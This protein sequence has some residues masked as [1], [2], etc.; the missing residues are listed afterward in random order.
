MSALLEVEG[1]VVRYGPAIAVD[2]VSLKL[3]AGERVA[4]I[5]PNGAGKSSLLNAICGL[6]KPAAGRVRVGG[7]NVTGR[8]PG[9]IVRLGVTQVPEGRQVFATLPVEANL[10]LG[11]FGREFRGELLTA[12]M[13]YVRRKTQV[14]ERLERVYELL[15]KLHE[16]RERPAGQT[17]GGEQQMV[18][19]GRALMAEPRLLAVDELSLGLAPLVV[20]GLCEFLRRLNEEEGVALLLVEQNAALAFELCERAYV[21]EAGRC[22]LEGPSSELERSELVRTAYLGG[23]LEVA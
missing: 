22:V 20:Q 4:L 10:L 21:L 6:F 15:P 11:A 5:G 7:R 3:G 9:E 13:R 17:S 18:A 16:L 1:L 2:G 12:T 19:I 14:Q 8:S 23:G